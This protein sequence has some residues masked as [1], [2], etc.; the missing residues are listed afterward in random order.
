MPPARRILPS[1]SG[2]SPPTTTSSSKKSY[3]DTKGGY[4]TAP[5]VPIPHILSPVSSCRSQ[6]NVDLALTSM[7][8]SSDHTAR[9]WEMASGD[10]VR[11]YNGHHKG[12]ATSLICALQ[13]LTESMDSGRML[14]FARW[15]RLTR[16]RVSRSFGALPGR[17]LYVVD[18]NTQ[19]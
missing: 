14:R 11:Q 17:W 9:L 19:P 8:A 7:L 4:G 3:R 1:R 10:T 15:R 16:Q 6:V 13:L 2:R 18:H 12:L 5:S